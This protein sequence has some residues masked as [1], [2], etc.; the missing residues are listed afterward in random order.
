MV[1][2]ANT[3]S[4]SVDAVHINEHSIRIAAI[5]EATLFARSARAATGLTQTEFAKRAGITRQTLNIIESA[6]CPTPPRLA[7]LIKIANAASG[8][9]KMSLNT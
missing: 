6:S 4:K 2:K 3:V 1:I 9:L 8:N 5:R 7:T